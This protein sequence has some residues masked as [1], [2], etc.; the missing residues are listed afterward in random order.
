[1][2]IKNQGVSMVVM[3][4]IMDVKG[5]LARLIAGEVSAKTYWQGFEQ[6][7]AAIANSGYTNSKRQ[8]NYSVK[9]HVFKQITIETDLPFVQ[10]GIAGQL[11]HGTS[12]EHEV[13]IFA[14][15]VPVG[16]R[17]NIVDEGIILQTPLHMIITAFIQR[18]F[19]RI[20]YNGKNADIV[21]KS[22]LKKEMDDLTEQIDDLVNSSPLTYL[23]PEVV[24]AASG[25][26]LYYRGPVEF[27]WLL[28][29]SQMEYEGIPST[30]RHNLDKHFGAAVNTVIAAHG[31]VDNAA[32]LRSTLSGYGVVTEGKGNWGRLPKT[33]RI[34][35]YLTNQML[36]YLESY[37]SQILA[38]FPEFMKNTLY[39]I[40]LTEEEVAGSLLDM[41]RTIR[42]LFNIHQRFNPLDQLDNKYELLA[43]I[44]NSEADRL[45]LDKV[46]L[47]DIRAFSHL[48]Y[49]RNGDI[50][51]RLIST[52]EMTMDV[53]RKVQFV[54]Q[55]LVTYSTWPDEEKSRLT[56]VA[57]LK[58]F[59]YKF[60][61][62]T[63][64]FEIV[65]G[66][67]VIDPHT[68]YKA[69]FADEN[70]YPKKM[71]LFYDESI[72][73]YNIAQDPDLTRSDIVKNDG[74]IQIE[75]STLALSRQMHFAFVGPD[76]RIYLAI[77]ND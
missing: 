17:C 70:S 11:I 27:P 61:D 66:H 9:R 72:M 1:M 2:I 68:V 48:T 39:G 16:I 20:A 41:G 62:V 69:I 26:E 56:Y 44:F 64:D 45:K 50:S 5:D 13:K 42:K 14:D 54:Q 8:T 60:A 34:N 32:T 35:R 31:A 15:R 67:H 28:G 74:T 25:G 29:V 37:G 52:G 40:D 73:L 3:N 18:E 22:R 43:A 59:R 19:A 30:V 7:A 49:I 33:T 65:A 10:N 58:I 21:A 36:S 23:F 71:L 77:R 47:E 55:N 51:F 53:Y 12:K 38:L 57:N 24:L 75:I 76:P 63:L 4:T 46:T 6:V